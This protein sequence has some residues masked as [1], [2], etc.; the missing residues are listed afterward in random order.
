MA[1]IGQRSAFLMVALALFGAD[2]AAAQEQTAEA[3]RE[4]RSDL[5]RER[6]DQLRTIQVGPP[7]KEFDVSANLTYAW[8]SNA[9]QDRNDPE[10][11]MHW[12]PDVS[13][14]W[15]R[16]FEDVRLTAR[17]GLSFDRYPSHSDLDCDEAYGHFK[18]EL[19][20]GGDMRWT[21]YVSYRPDVSFEPLLSR[22]TQTTHDVAAGLS[23]MFYV[24]GDGEWISKREA[25]AAGSG[26]FGFDIQGGWRFSDPD[27]WSAAFVKAKF[28]L[29]AV[30][31]ERVVAGAQPL[32]TVRW[33]PDYKGASRRDIRPGVNFGVTWAPSWL[34]GWELSA[35]AQ[36]VRNVSTRSKS[37]FTQW[38]AGP[39]VSMRLKF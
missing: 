29:R 4:V 38:E 23:N 10:A 1:R 37:E 18:A 31:S 20:D 22:R 3:D 12:I 21:P 11:E 34:D 7:A 36:Y 5:T 26:Y 35:G 13:L 28:P 8:N 27:D 9:A 33:Y 30:V 17:A 32:L 19:T 6:R 24:N 14:G 2:G 25:W 39:T 16:Q 15:R